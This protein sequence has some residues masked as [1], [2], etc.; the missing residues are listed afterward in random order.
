MIILIK[1]DWRYSFHPGVLFIIQLL[2]IV[3][4]LFNLSLILNW[5]ISYFESVYAP[6]LTTINLLTSTVIF[7]K[8]DKNMQANFHMSLSW[9]ILPTVKHFSLDLLT[10]LV[11]QWIKSQQCNPKINDNNVHRIISFVKSVRTLVMW[12]K[13]AII[14]SPTSTLLLVH[15]APKITLLSPHQLS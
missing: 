8:K 11:Q 3:I 15:F 5:V 6:F 14:G 7:N 4:W 1:N 9:L 10:T 12:K 13:I 2:I